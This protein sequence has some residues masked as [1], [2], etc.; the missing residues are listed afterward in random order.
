M[1]RRCATRPLRWSWPPC[2]PEPPAVPTSP[3]AD[4]FVYA[5]LGPWCQKVASTPMSSST[6]S[7][8]GGPESALPL[9]SDGY[10]VQ[11]G[12]NSSRVLYMVQVPKIHSLEHRATPPLAIAAK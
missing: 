11:L 3:A 6:P 8:L 10:R 12:A 1:L 5:C 2:A 7:S 9:P 4:S